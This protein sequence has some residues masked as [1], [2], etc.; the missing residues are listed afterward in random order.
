MYNAYFSSTIYA[1]R[2]KESFT[3]SSNGYSNLW[4]ERTPSRCSS[5]CGC[6][7]FCSLSTYRVPVKSSLLSGLR[8]STLI[9]LPPSRRMILGGGDLYF[10]RLPSFELQKNCYEINCSFNERTVCNTSRRILKGRHL[11]AASRKGREACHSFDSDDVESILSLLSEEADKDACDIK[12]K[13]VSSSKRMEAKKKRNNVSKERKLSLVKKVETEKK[14]FLKQHE[15]AT[16]DLRREDEKSNKEKEA[17]T[18]SENHR[19][20]KDVSSSSFYSHSS[21]VFVSDLEVQD[22]HDLEELSVGYEKDAVKHVEVKGTG[23]LNRQRDDSKKLHGVSNQERTAFGA[24]INWNLRKK[25]EKKLT[26]VTMQETISTKEHQD[27]HSTAVRTHEPSHGKASISEKQVRS[28]E[29]NSSFLKDLDRRME[30]AYIKAGKIRKHQSTDTQ[31]AD[32]EVE[33]TLSSQKRQ[34]GR[35]GN[36]EISETLLQERSD[37]HKKFV[38]STSTKGNETLKSKMFSGRE[39]NLEISETRLRETQ[40]ER[41]KFGGST[42]PTRKDVIN[43]NSRKYMGESKVEDTERTLNTRMNNLGEK[44]ISILSSGQGIEEQKHQKGKK[45]GYEVESTLSSQK[46]QSGREGNLEISETL[47]QERRD[48]HK[49]FVGSTSTTGNE[50]LKSKKA[51][52]GREES[53][54]T[55]E[56]LLRE[57]RDECR[58]FGGSTSTTGKDVINRNSQKYMGESKVEDTERTLNTRMK[59]LGAKKISILSSVQGIE[60]QKHQNGEKTITQAKERRKFQQF[61]EVSQVHESK[62]EDTSTVKSRTRIN[63][64][65]GNS[66]LSTDT[67]GTRRQTDK[68]TNQSIQ[69]GKG[70]EHENLEISETRL[71]ETQDERRKFG[72]STS[73]TRKDVINRNSRKY[74]G[75]SKVEDT[76]R[77]LNTRMNNLGEKKISILS[78]GQGIEE[79]KHQKG[80][81][82]GYEVESTLSS[83]KTQSG[84]EGNLEISETLLQERRDEHKKF[85]GSTSTTGNET[86]KSKKAFSGREESLETSET[87]LRETRDECRKFGGSTSTTGKDVINRNSQKYMGE[88]KVEDTERTLNT[89]MKNLGAK[90]IS[91]LSSVQGIEEQKHQN[92][93]KTITQAKERRKFQQFSEVSQVH[94]SKVEDTSTVKSRTRINDW[95]GN[96][97]LSTDTRGTRRQ[98]DKM[99]NQS[100]Q[101]GKGSEH[102]ITL[103][104][105]YASDEKQVSTSQGSFGKVRFIPKSKSTKVVKTRESSRQTDERIANFDLHTEDQRP[106]NLSISDET[107]SREEARFHGSQDLVSE[108]G[109]HVKFAEGG[110]QSSP[111]MSFRSSFG[112]MGRD[113]KHIELTAGVAS[114]GIIVESSDRGSSTLYDNSGRSSVLLSGSYST[115]GTDQAYSKPSNIIALEGAT[116]SADRLQKSPKQFVGEHVERIRHEVTTSEM[117]EMEVTGTKLAIED[118]GNQIDSSRRQGPQN[119]SQPKEHGSNRSSGVHGTEGPSVEMLDANEPS[120]KQSLV[121]GE[122]KISKDTEKTIVSRTGRSMWSMFGDLVR[123]GWGTPAGSSTSAGRSSESKLSN[124]SG[125]ETRFSGQEHEET[126]KS[127]VIKETGV[128]PQ[129]ISSDRSKVST[130]YTQ[131]VGEVSDTKKQKDKGKHLEEANANWSDDGKELKVTTSGIKNVELPVLL[132][133]RGPPVVGEIVNIGGSDMPGTESVV[134]IKEPVAPVQSVSSGLGKKNGELMQRKFQQSKQVLRDRFDDWEEAYQLEFEQRRMDEMFMKEALLEAKKAADAWEVPVG[135]VLVQDGK[136][137]ARGSNLVEELRDS[138]AHAEMI[139]IREAS[140]LLRT[141]RLSDSILYVTLEPCPM[142][143]GAILQ[144]RIDTVVWGAPNK[145]LGADGSWIRL[146]PDGGESS[147]EPRDIPPAP[148]HPFHPK[149][150]IRRG[151]LAAECADVM[152]QF[153]QLRRR[154]KKE[155]SSN[156]PS[157]LAVTHHHPSKFIDKI[158]D[159]F[160]VMFCL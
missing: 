120:T 8:Q 11:V 159:I 156:D 79:Q 116:G 154:K 127:N 98:T 60:E 72:G 29:D 146:F 74:M 9:Q 92:G 38:G 115:D 57:T 70:S 3:L 71:R 39:E 93:E 118:E 150:K 83:Q 147:S 59:N 81:K 107:A 56:T 12:L 119:D 80:K 31:K 148:V 32:S 128:L 54:E 28:E 102:V 141:W 133:A 21:G 64:W 42:S 103:S 131:S 105:G 85:V 68:M 37:E 140:N 61:S 124:K 48:E 77:T 129:I 82:F 20:Q 7:D 87:L 27:K 4:Y 111:L 41:R 24:D 86:L 10:S 46:T 14:G 113:T 117:E 91:I 134:P 66:N 67:R 5:R 44:K 151:V 22:K 30:K 122:P 13:N 144:A 62:V 123:L 138:T 160:H 155:E 25:S 26:N 139:C 136:I 40:D 19:K 58:K 15:V 114:T 52:S 36:L 34:S 17:F 106:R 43:R 16:T 84:R 65:E 63:D 97:N 51:F 88:S 142:C 108:A 75:E 149:I 143:A 101:H 50:T 90:K 99:T 112:L 45:F 94:E 126:S 153:F 100:I 53:L 6:C 69:H 23:E 78:S 49:K 35:E 135:A 110:E 125:S 55:S 47:L 1:V 132:P 104:E 158:N 33:S 76:E 2:C 95:E 130:P 121:A 145:L 157:S 73:P 89:R 109:K 18:K 137:I 96:S 152:Q